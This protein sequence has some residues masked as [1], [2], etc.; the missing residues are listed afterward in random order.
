MNNFRPPKTSVR[1]Y[2]PVNQLKDIDYAKNQIAPSGGPLTLPA[3]PP[4]APK[5]NP[6]AFQKLKAMFAQK[7]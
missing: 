1:P 5:T 3:P 6:M 7:K 2:T 4:M